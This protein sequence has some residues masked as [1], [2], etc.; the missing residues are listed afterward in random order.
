MGCKGLVYL[1]FGAAILSTPSSCKCHSGDHRSEDEHDIE[2]QVFDKISKVS[3]RIRQGLQ[4][5]SCKEVILGS[6]PV[7]DGVMTHESERTHSKTEHQQGEVERKSE[8]IP[9]ERFRFQ[10]AHLGGRI[11]N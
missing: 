6:C 7:N 9:S 4:R 5:W 11:P 1:G 3:N 10:V 2:A 8:F